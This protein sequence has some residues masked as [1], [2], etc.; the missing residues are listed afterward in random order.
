MRKRYGNFFLDFFNFERRTKVTGW[1]FN[2]VLIIKD[3]LVI[4]KLISGQPAIQ[5]Y[6]EANNPLG[7]LQAVV[8]IVS[9]LR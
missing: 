7:P 4:Y 5:E 2:A 1:E 6:E 8:P 3:D 9:P